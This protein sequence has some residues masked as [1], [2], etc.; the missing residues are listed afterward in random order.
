[1]QEKKSREIGAAGT[2]PV[3]EKTS[4][5]AEKKSSVA[6]KTPPVAEKTS[7]VAEKTSQAETSTSHGAL[8]ENGSTEVL[9]SKQIHDGRVVN[10]SVDRVRLPNNAE[11]NLEIVRHP[12]AAAMV[13]VDEQGN[14]YLVRQ[15]RYATGGFILEVP[16]GKLDNGEDPAHCARREL[17]EEIGKK[18]N[19]LVSLG[20]IWTSPGFSDE[21]IH[22][23]LAKD[24]E[25]AEQALEEN[26][27][28]TVECIPFVKALE[29]AEKGEITDSKTVCALFRANGKL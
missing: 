20:W 17:V 21:K 15:Y 26:E 25:P 12:G 2:S 9:E 1:M 19:N 6:E 14:V 13:P 22:V 8:W 16:A 10:L 7:P 18:T 27:V 11:V 5:V 29:M 4:P 28:L 3:G 23:Y 24:L